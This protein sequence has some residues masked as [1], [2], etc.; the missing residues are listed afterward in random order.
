MAQ[1]LE[2]KALAERKAAYLAKRNKK[3]IDEIEIE[4]FCLTPAATSSGDTVLAAHSHGAGMA[5]TCAVVVIFWQLM[6]FC[7]PLMK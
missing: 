1:S 3:S 7:G 4:K 6:R 2:E 5:V